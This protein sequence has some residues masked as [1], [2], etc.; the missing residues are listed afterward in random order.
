MV[1]SENVQFLHLV[2]RTFL[3]KDIN[4]FLF[5]GVYTRNC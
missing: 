1:L 2:P 3:K 4:D 5:L